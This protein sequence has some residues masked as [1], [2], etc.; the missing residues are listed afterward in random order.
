MEPFRVYQIAAE[1]AAGKMTGQYVEAAGVL[2][3]SS[4]PIDQ[5]L[6]DEWKIDD[7]IIGGQIRLSMYGDR[8]AR[9][10]VPLNSDPAFRLLRLFTSLAGIRN[11]LILNGLEKMHYLQY[12][13][14]LELHTFIDH[15]SANERMNMFLE[16][17]L[18]SWRNLS[19]QKAAN[20]AVL[21]GIDPQ[22]SEHEMRRLFGEWYKNAEIWSTRIAGFSHQADQFLREE[23]GVEKSTLAQG[24]RCYLVREPYNPND[25]NAIAV[26]HQSG[27]KMGYLRR[28]IAEYIAPIIDLGAVFRAKV[29]AFLP[30]DCPVSARV[31]LAVER[32]G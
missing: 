4:A 16:A 26:L 12:A 10:L 20:L 15:L 24:D 22:T 25:P 14:G 6:F 2:Q 23:N 19:L 30:D 9:R 28:T 1:T 21:A 7:A 29:R 5:P 18:G 8:Q 3:P 32:V 17:I 31:Y 27:K 11:G 13:D